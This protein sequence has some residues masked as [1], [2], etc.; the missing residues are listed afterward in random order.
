MI[1]YITKPIDRYMTR[2]KTE[3]M[4]HAMTNYECPLCHGTFSKRYFE[5]HVYKVHG[6]RADECFAMLFGLPNPVR[7]SCGK[8]LRY[9]MV[10][11]GYPDRCGSCSTGS[12]S[13]AEY[14]TPEEARLHV[15]QLEQMLAEAKLEEKRLKKEA[16][17]NSVPLGSLPFPS[18][19]DSRFLKKLSL[20]IRIKTAN[21]DKDGL[22]EIANIVDK[23]LGKE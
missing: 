23:M 18:R 1:K 12:L 15:E 5:D 2:I 7:C 8:E 10:K 22:F 4:V 3:N 9:S 16:E 20:E 6:T 19:K 14:N 17:L 21:G 11:K 13:K